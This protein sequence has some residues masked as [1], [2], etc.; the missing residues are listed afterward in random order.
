MTT[1]ITIRT[2]AGSSPA[3]GLL[4]AFGVSKPNG[5]AEVV[6]K[7][8]E[9]G[10]SDGVTLDAVVDAA[11]SA[12]TKTFAEDDG[13]QAFETVFGSDEPEPD[14]EASDDETLN[15]VVRWMAEMNVSEE[16]A[17]G[18]VTHLLNR[19]ILFRERG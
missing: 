11:A 7:T 5:L 6:L 10:I 12:F 8:Q 14:E 1:T 2:Q 19:G 16:T 4:G 18:L 3:P 13:T 15:K 9:I 17:G